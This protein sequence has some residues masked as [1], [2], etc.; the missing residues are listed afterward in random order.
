MVSEINLFF[1]VWRQKELEVEL[2]RYRNL[3][4]VDKDLHSCEQ[5]IKCPYK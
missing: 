1:F 4:P 5:Y 3:I 2:L